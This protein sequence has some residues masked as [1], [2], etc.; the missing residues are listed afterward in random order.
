M[1]P[2]FSPSIAPVCAHRQQALN[3]RLSMGDYV[4]MQSAEQRSKYTTTADQ[5]Y[6]MNLE[7]I[8]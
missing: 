8:L 5:S 6:H 3:D 1:T 4:D 2:V 7:T